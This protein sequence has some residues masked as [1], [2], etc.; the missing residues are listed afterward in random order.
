[1]AKIVD[2]QFAQER[3]IAA[4]SLDL[5]QLRARYNGGESS[6]LPCAGRAE[7]DTFLESLIRH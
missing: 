2:K 3:G 4:G 7:L 5:G 1:M 6:A